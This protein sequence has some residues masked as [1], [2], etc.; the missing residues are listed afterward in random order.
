MTAKRA[1]YISF[2]PLKAEI[3]VNNISKF[4]SYP[5]ENIPFPL[6]RPIG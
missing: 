4:V 1:I 2:N 3:N 5:S 6:Q